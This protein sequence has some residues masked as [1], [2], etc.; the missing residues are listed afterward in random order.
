MMILRARWTKILSGNR[1]M[2]EGDASA[3]IFKFQD[4]SKQMAVFFNF[5]SL[6][7]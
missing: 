2:S 1:I 6:K 3:F 7:W 5:S 4:K